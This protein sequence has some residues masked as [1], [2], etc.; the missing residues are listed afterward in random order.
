ML[1]LHRLRLLREFAERG[2]IAATAAALGYTPSA[3]SQQLA[4]LEREAGVPLLDRAAR[5]VELTDAGRRLAVHAEI[6]L[7]QVEAAEADLS[8]GEQEP[9]GRVCVA[10]FPSAAVA[11][12]PALARSLRAHPGL[13]LLLRQ[14]VT[15]EGLRLVRSGEVDVAIVDDWS[16]RLAGQ[17]PGTLRFYLLLRDPLVLAV[18]RGH[19][20]ADPAVPVDLRVLR[21]TSRW[22]AAPA[23]EPSRQA[24]DRLLEAAGGT[25]A[26]PWEFEGLGTILALVGRGIGV[27]AVP[28]L[29]LAAGERGV[30][31]R[32]LAGPV[33][34]RQIWAVV[35]A[36]S[37][38][39]A[40]VALV[41]AALHRGAAGL[42]GPGRDSGPG[43]EQ[44][45][46]RRKA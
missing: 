2:T 40:S 26:V 20:L 4:A 19:R 21:E 27:A 42:A 25:P 14:A 24:V 29:A 10:A 8:A 37:A 12:A 16:G 34:A 30:M 45:P 15:A 5:S 3:V 35:R 46:R 1:D 33:P 44:R 36:A 32:E 7:A 22:L 41:L 39:R 11:F 6:I 18:P 13:T 9:S 31:V 43:P 17:G 38:R 23:G 28:R